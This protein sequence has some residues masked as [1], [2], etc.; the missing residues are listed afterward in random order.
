MVGEHHQLKG[1]GFEQIPGDGGGEKPGVL[2]TMG[3]DTSQGQ[4]NSISC[5]MFCTES[6]LMHQIKRVFGFIPPK[7]KC[8]LQH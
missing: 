5:F 4:N 6:S 1:H 7:V 8:I 3:S 2:Q